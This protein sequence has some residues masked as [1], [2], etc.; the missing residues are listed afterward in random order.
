MFNIEDVSSIVLQQNS[1]T[2]S[3]DN[4]NSS[5]RSNILN[6]HHQKEEEEEQVVDMTT[7]G[8]KE[9]LLNS[10]KKF[11][12]NN[13]PYKVLQQR[14]VKINSR[15]AYECK[16]E[17]EMKKSI[18][19]KHFK[20][21]EKSESGDSVK[22]LLYLVALKSDETNK[23]FTLQHMTPN[24]DLENFEN[25]I[26]NNISHMVRSIKLVQTQ[27]VGGFTLERK[28][29]GISMKLL[30]EAWQCWKVSELEHDFTAP[31]RKSK[32]TDSSTKLKMESLIELPNHLRNEN[33]LLYLVSQHSK[34]QIGKEFA[35]IECTT[36][37]QQETFEQ[38][39]EHRKVSLKKF[40][41]FIEI[42]ERINFGDELASEGILFAYITEF[43]SSPVHSSKLLPTDLTQ[44]FERYNAIECY[45]TRDSKIYKIFSRSHFS[46]SLS[47]FRESIISQFKCLTFKQPETTTDLLDNTFMTFKSEEHKFEIQVP[48]L[49]QVSAK[50]SLGNTPVCQFFSRYSMLNVL[51]MFETQIYFEL[52]GHISKNEHIL[53]DATQ[54]LETLKQSLH[55]QMVRNL[56]KPIPLRSESTLVFNDIEARH[57][58]FS[59]PIGSPI[60]QKNLIHAHTNFLWVCPSPQAILS[61]SKSPQSDTVYVVTIKS[62]VMESFFTESIEKLLQQI[63]STFK[64]V[65]E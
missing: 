63:H 12:E 27:Q 57:V 48:L 29:L 39:L 21:F 53:T 40:D 6:Q 47:S 5:S 45:F 62:N 17:L 32:A 22:V 11:E 41:N 1:N 56:G 59:T 7:F 23:F 18:L 28:D 42:S 31:T 54:R 52:I 35:L 36:A 19:S 30:D 49:Y 8:P 15:K 55:S 9:H 10:L 24:L 4:N 65:K 51:H 46:Q 14:A 64:L 16:L 3:N 20:Q 44:S 34:D 60:H 2:S 43:E 61:Q 33:V 26:E 38:I 50:E 58:V 25:E 37:E 13:F